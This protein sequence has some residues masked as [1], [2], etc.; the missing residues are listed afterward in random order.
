MVVGV[1]A[2]AALAAA[3]LGLSGLY[4]QPVRPVT[5]SAA[6]ADPVAGSATGLGSHGGCWPSCRVGWAELCWRP[7]CKVGRCLGRQWLLRW[8]LLG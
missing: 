2:A 3:G 5:E 6:A 8:Q 4:P 1:A 7:V